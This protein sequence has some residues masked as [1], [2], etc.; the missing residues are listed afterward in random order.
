MTRL[1][2]QIAAAAN[3]FYWAK[4]RSGRASECGALSA[5]HLAR[6]DSRQWHD[7]AT[8]NTSVAFYFA[9]FA[10]IRRDPARLVTA[11]K[12]RLRR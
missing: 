11:L 10:A 12:L 4:N 2:Y 6:H 3:L 1:W 9:I 8:E 7:H 5:L